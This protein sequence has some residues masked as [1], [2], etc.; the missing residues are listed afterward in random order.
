MG[1]NR[2]GNF[3][4]F[5]V[6]MSCGLRPVLMVKKY[7]TPKRIPFL[8]SIPRVHTS[9][10]LDVDHY[11]GTFTKVHGKQKSKPLPHQQYM[12]DVMCVW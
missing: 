5:I 2:Y 7:A 6:S 9:R 1:T 12:C 8:E 4:Y 3:Y 10:F 11:Y